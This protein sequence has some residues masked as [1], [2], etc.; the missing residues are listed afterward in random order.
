[1][2]PTIEVNGLVPDGVT[3]VGIVHPDATVT[4]SPVD[5]NTVDSV[6]SEPVVGIRFQAPDGS[7]VAVP[8]YSCTATC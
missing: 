1:V 6:V 2:P 3:A 7:T 8:A 5:G 4:S